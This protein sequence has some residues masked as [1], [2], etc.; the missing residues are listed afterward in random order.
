M[1]VYYFQDTI[2][3][4]TDFILAEEPEKLNQITRA[5]MFNSYEILDVIKYLQ[6]VKST[7][8]ISIKA[9][10]KKAHIF[11]NYLIA[12]DYLKE[13]YNPE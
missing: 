5:V 13:L 9:V 2:L 6:I 4:D 7:R 8:P 12:I 3:F 1:K 11:N 10:N